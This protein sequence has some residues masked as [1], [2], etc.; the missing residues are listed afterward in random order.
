MKKM[1]PKL[2]ALACFALAIIIL[3]A[4]KP[5]KSIDDPG[6]LKNVL[7]SFFQGIATQDF[8]K[9][10]MATTGDFIL[11]EDGRLWNMDSAFMNIKNRMPYTVK[12]QMD[13]MKFFV[14]RESG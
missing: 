2:A 12:F 14:D 7:N 11:Y 4:G 13:N 8:E 5:N 6:K 1:K 9:L 3:T 10:R